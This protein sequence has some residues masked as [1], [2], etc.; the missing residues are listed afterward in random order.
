MSRAILSGVIA[1]FLTVAAS[2]AHAQGNRATF[3]GLWQGL[4]SVD[5]SLR[6]ISIANTDVRGV[7]EIRAHDTYWSL[8]GGARATSVSRGQVTGKGILQSKGAVK[9]DNGKEIEIENVFRAEPFL[10][11][12]IIREDLVGKPFK[13][14]LF[15]INR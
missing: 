10:E 12:G 13:N 2:A 8:C 15:R 1:L 4:D 14:L 5:G 7:Y 3:V 11:D 6:T 9:C